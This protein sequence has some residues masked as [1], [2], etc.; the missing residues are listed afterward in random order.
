[1]LPISEAWRVRVMVTMKCG[2]VGQRQ[3]GSR[4]HSW[5]ILSFAAIDAQL[6]YAAPSHLA[7]ITNEGQ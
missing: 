7:C 4:S 6:L 5:M 1:M 2:S 3:S